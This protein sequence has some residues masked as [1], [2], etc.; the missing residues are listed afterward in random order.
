MFLQM[1]GKWLNRGIK[2]LLKNKESTVYFL[3]FLEYFKFISSS[4]SLR[5]LNIIFLH[6]GL[7]V[8]ADYFL[9]FLISFS[10]TL[11]FVKQG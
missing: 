10:V 2:Y 1:D 9:T 7:F 11:F 6:G 4:L 3:L 5:F 8:F